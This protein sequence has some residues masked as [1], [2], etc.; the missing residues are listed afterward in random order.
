MNSKCAQTKLIVI[1]WFLM[2]L[3]LLLSRKDKKVVYRLDIKPR[4]CL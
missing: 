1:V 2:K 3:L 4:S